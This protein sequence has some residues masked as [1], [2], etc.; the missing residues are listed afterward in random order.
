MPLTFSNPIPNLIGGGEY[1]ICDTL[2]IDILSQRSNSS[3]NGGVDELESGSSAFGTLKRGIGVRTFSKVLAGC[4]L[5]TLAAAWGSIT[6]VS[7]RGVRHKGVLGRR[8]CTRSYSGVTH[9]KLSYVCLGKDAHI[10]FQTFLAQ[11]RRRR[12][13]WTSNCWTSCVSIH[14][15]RVK[16]GRSRTVRDGVVVCVLLSL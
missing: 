13:G 7:A 5:S 14:V 9:G 10:S 2:P 8:L 3:M 15:D 6:A 16:E 12:L 1:F 4:H 11:R